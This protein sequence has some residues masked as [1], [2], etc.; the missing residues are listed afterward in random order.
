MS[1]PEPVRSLGARAASDQFTRE[2][3]E[4]E[5]L[6]RV[7]AGDAQAFEALF[8][9]FVGPLCSFAYSYVE[10]ESLAQ[11]IV[12]DLFTRL[13][14]RRGT[15]ERPRSVRAYLYG[16][17][18]NRV[19]NELR[20]ARVE[21]AFLT[22]ALRLEAARTEGPRPVPPEDDLNA[23]ALAA[24][25]QRAVAEL[26][27]RCREVFTL[28]RDRQLSYAEAAEVLGIS[29]KTVEI[30]VGRALALLRKHLADWLR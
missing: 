10:S 21:R 9:A 27:P 4:L 20:H 6:D 11:E 30:H 8:R 24:A 26:P 2:A 23:S 12:Q 25:V 14:D 1:S 17:T 19:L 16:A 15:L 3:R 13:W 29:P 28:T 18:R 5:W 22:R 7:R